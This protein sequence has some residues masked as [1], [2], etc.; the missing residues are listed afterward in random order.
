MSISNFLYL[1]SKYPKRENKRKNELVLFEETSTDV[2]V[3]TAR[4]VSIKTA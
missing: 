2:L 4:E 1:S 3:D